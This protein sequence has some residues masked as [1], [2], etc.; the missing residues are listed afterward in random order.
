MNCLPNLCLLLLLCLRGLD[1]EDGESRKTR[2]L[3]GDLSRHFRILE[4][5]PEL[6]DERGLTPLLQVS[7]LK[8]RQVITMDKEKP[9]LIGHAH[10]SEAYHER[11]RLQESDLD[12]S[13]MDSG[14][15]YGS[16]RLASEIQTEMLQNVA[17]TPFIFTTP[18]DRIRLFAVMNGAALPEAFYTNTSLNYW[19]AAG[20]VHDWESAQAPGKMVY[21]KTK[22]RINNA[23]I[24]D[25]TGGWKPDMMGNNFSGNTKTLENAY[26]DGQALRGARTAIRT[27]AAKS[28]PGWSSDLYSGLRTNTGP[29]KSDCDT[30]SESDPRCFADPGV[31]LSVYE[32]AGNKVIIFHSDW[33][34]NW[35]EYVLWQNRAWIIDE[36]ENQVKTQW[37]IDGRQAVNPEMMKRKGSTLDENQERCAFKDEVNWPI[38]DFAHFSKTLDIPENELRG[39][40]YWQVVK[41]ILRVALPEARDRVAERQKNVYLT[42]SGYGGVWAALSSMWLKKVDDA[43]YPTFSIAG[44]GF[45]CLARGLAGDVFP[46]DT[47]SQINVYAHVM[48]IYARMDYV[49]GYQCL[50]GLWNMT[51]NTAVHDFCG[52]IVGFSGPQLLYRGEPFGEYQDKKAKDKVHEARLLFDACHYYTHSPWYAAILFL[53][54]TVLMPDG[55]TDGGCRTL[56]GIK[57][58][59]KLGKCPT[60]SRVDADCE[61]IASTTQEF[62]LV[63][64]I[65][66]A[67]SL[68][69][70]IMCIAL[71]GYVMLQRV[72]NDMWV[73]GHDKR[74]AQKHKSG[75]CSS[76]LGFL[77]LSSGKGKGSSKKKGDRAKQARER[78]KQI[79]QNKIDRGKNKGKKKKVSGKTEAEKEEEWQALK[80]KMDSVQ[81]EQIGKA[82]GDL[83]QAAAALGVTSS[84]V[85]YNNATSSVDPLDAIVEEEDAEPQLDTFKKD[86]R[87][88]KD[89]SK[90][91]VKS[92]TGASSSTDNPKKEEKERR[93]LKSK[94]A[95][96]RAK[97]PRPKGGSDDGD[98]SR[99]TTRKTKKAGSDTNLSENAN[100][101]LLA[102]PSSQEFD[103]DSPR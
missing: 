71:V 78:A 63:A 52:R 36:L 51:E 50:Y 9:W 47:H 54:D 77:G 49:S 90:T 80:A 82:D 93:P 40:G 58:N 28:T 17:A 19:A 3:R 35:Y 27:A 38:K 6:L 48:D 85:K 100:A 16:R 33:T 21:T 75:C 37:T 15:R 20:K 84:A 46:W 56:A 81:V 98:G 99:K 72:K 68:A 60:A 61:A 43:V 10:F 102:A 92:K 55:T 2:R 12:S 29:I 65:A 76:C 45:Q 83:S 44:G 91:T 14:I 69:G 32:D 101:S 5:E 86:K 57:Q 53:S 31:A 34:L 11:R 70:F 95:P 94:T 30:R 26:R 79:R 96:S 67:S 103:A 66:V 74:T 39:K 88:A 59:D 7:G 62:P 25:D 23:T 42:G 1:A 64:C 4:H 8:L 97:S 41:R 13:D 24:T 87:P 89:R 18:R 22:A 73:F